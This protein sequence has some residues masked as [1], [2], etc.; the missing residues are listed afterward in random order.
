MILVQLLFSHVLIMCIY[1]LKRVKKMQ[2]VLVDVDPTH[3]NSL[4]S[5]F[6]AL[7]VN[8]WQFGMKKVKTTKLYE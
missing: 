2:Y 1:L 8:G 7:M 3:G 6:Y 5:L 4:F